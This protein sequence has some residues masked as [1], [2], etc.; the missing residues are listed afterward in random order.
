MLKKENKTIM[1]KDFKKWH[2]K[3]SQIHNERNTDFL[4]VKEKDIWWC[5]LGAN[6]GFEQ[7][8]K[9]SWYERPVLIFK[10]FS[11]HLIWAIPLSTK[12]KN[13]PY[14]IPCPSSDGMSRM[15]IISQMRMIDTKRFN[16]KMGVIS[17]KTFSEIKKAVV[18]I[19]NPPLS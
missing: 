7:D 14:Y 12:I 10:K 8:G 13:N 1:Q 19:I 18:N 3:K 16:E 5:S 4:Y 11:R 15:A 17:E 2:N 6:V 9:G